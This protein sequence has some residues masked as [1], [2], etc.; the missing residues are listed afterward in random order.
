[1]MGVPLQC[2]AL[3]VRE[4][5][6]LNILSSLIFSDILLLKILDVFFITNI[7]NIC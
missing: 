6:C 4:E 5:V 3:L 2:S 1:M 7:A